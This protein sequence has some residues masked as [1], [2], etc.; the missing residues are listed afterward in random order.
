[1]DNTLEGKLLFAQNA[2]TNALNYEQVKNL[3]AEFGYTEERLQ[4][5]R[6]LYEAASAL[7][8]KQQKEMASRLKLPIPSMPPNWRKFAT[9]AFLMIPRV[10]NPA[11]HTH[12]LQKTPPPWLQ[13]CMIG[14]V[15]NWYFHKLNLYLHQ[16]GPGP[17]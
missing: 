16:Y 9:C 17:L 2:I 14:L 1:M 6:Q 13:A 8:L 5:G 15:I 12:I 11:K 7:Q 10:C 4:E 3:V